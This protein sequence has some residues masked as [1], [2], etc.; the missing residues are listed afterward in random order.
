MEARATARYVRVTPRKV[1]QVLDLVRGRAVD[2]ALTTLSFSK[3]HVAKKIEKTMRS[4]VA[5]AIQADSSVDVEDLFYNVPARRKFLRAERTE[6]R[7]ADLL[8]R[9]FA[10]GR[11][12]VGFELEH[13]GRSVS[14]LPPA[15]SDG[16]RE[17][18][19]K[20]VQAALTGDAELVRQAV[21][22]DP[23][24]GAVCNTEEIW[25]MCGEMF[26]A[27]APWMPQFNSEG[28]TWPDIPQ[29]AGGILRS[30]ESA[31][32]WLPPSLSAG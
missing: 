31:G 9:R 25:A 3:K 10:L 6:F 19:L 29:P 4:A 11:F 30:P 16:E 22:H 20:A 8:L 23:L 27:L 24:T 26:E 28:R 7:Q 15:L 32:D 21:M 5:N 18:R 14:A 1:N 17:R 12:D 13:N 2:E